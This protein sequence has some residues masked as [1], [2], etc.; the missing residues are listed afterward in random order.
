MIPDWRGDPDIPQE[1]RVRCARLGLKRPERVG[2]TR[3]FCATTASGG[4]CACDG[5]CLRPAT[6]AELRA[7]LEGR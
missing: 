3:G 1:L 5:S 2:L 4:G 7:A 6:E